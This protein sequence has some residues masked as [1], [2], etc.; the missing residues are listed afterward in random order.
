MLVAALIYV[1][2]SK[3]HRYSNN[4]F[5]LFLGTGYFFVA[6]LDFFHL[7]TYYNPGTVTNYGTN[8][9]T[10]LWVAGRILQGLTFCLAPLFIKKNPY[11]ITFFSFSI[12]TILLLTSIFWFKSFPDCFIPGVGLTSF[13]IGT[14][15]A[16]MLLA[17]IGVILVFIKRDI[18]GKPLCYIMISAMFIFV[19]SEQSF[20]LYTNVTGKMNF[21]GHILKIISYYL[22]YRG[23]VLRGLRAPFDSIF[24]ELK[25][26][27]TRDSLTGLYN[28]QGFMELARQELVKARVEKNPLGILMVD[29]DKFKLV[30][31]QFG[32]Q[33]GDEV[34]K[35]FARI[36]EDAVPAKGF[37]CRL[38]GDEFTALIPGDTQLLGLTR[39]KIKD[40]VAIWTASDNM[41]RELGVSI[42]SSLWET[43]DPE[44][45][46]KLLKTAD[47][48][49]YMEKQAK[50]Y[51]RN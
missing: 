49:M 14:E 29:L 2:A 3:T 51:S 32:H 9:P 11:R 43:G 38:G 37:T 25:A 50:K 1:L 39:Q 45:V 36:M 17:L 24:L 27:I 16:V 46:D 10:Q 13:K 40:A 35:H 47:D 34:L 6:V 44:D 15:Y 33:A 41:V 12:L 5:L 18:I 30:N 19:L 22:V 21:I 28:R 7:L 48:E 42:G 26:S 31:D 20:T 8:I 23:I 4:N